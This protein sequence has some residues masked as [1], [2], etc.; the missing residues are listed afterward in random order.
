M[1][2]WFTI[3]ATGAGV[4]TIAIAIP[5]I[6]RRVPPNGLY[7]L[8]VPAT[9]ADEW[10]WY[11]ANARFGR[12][13]VFLGTLLIILGVGLPLFGL[14]TTAYLAWATIGGCGAIAI[15]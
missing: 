8:R 12:S 6:L 2:I 10:V 15:S 7:G 11:E 13:L 14:G 4:L 9:F 1:K 3:V 5:L